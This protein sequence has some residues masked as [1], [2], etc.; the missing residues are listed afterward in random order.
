[1]TELLVDSAPDFLKDE[2]DR[3][4]TGCPE[5]GSFLDA[6]RLNPETQEVARKCIACQEW[7][8]AMRVPSRWEGSE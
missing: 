3:W 8:F 7:H 5:C 4:S 6:P 2:L 1:M